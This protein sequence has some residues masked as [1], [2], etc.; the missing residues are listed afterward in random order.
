MSAAAGLAM[1]YDGT[2]TETPSEHRAPYQ[3]SRYGARWAPVL[4]SWTDEQETRSLAGAAV[5]LGGSLAES[6]PDG[7]RLYATGE[8]WLDTPTLTRIMREPT[9]AAQVRAVIEHELGHVLGLGHVQS[10]AALMAPE[11]H[12]LVVAPGPG[13][14]AGLAVLA[15]Q[16]CDRRF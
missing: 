12:L 9:G 8:V 4:I 3:P 11:T 14:L 6:A 10:P 13:D 16:P 1:V 7:R 15:N 2:T 5:G